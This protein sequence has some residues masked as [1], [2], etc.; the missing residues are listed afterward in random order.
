VIKRLYVL[1]KQKAEFSSIAARVQA[2]LFL[3][4][5]HRGADLS[6][7]LAKI[8]T[9]SPGA[10]PFI[11]DVHWN[12]LAIQAINDEFPQYCQ[13]LQLFSFYETEPTNLL[14]GKSFVLDK[15]L[16]TLGYVNERTA[17]LTANHRG[18]CKYADKK[19]PNYLTVRNALA[20]IIDSFQ[21]HTA[22]S[23]TNLNHEEQKLLDN[24]LGTSTAAE[25][26]FM[27]VDTLRMSGSCEWLMRKSSYQEWQES[28]N[29]QFYWISAKPATGK[30][31]LSGKVVRHLRDLNRDCQFY[32]FD[33]SD[34]AKSTITSFLLSMAG[35]MALL[36][37]EILRV[38]LRL[39]KEDQ[40]RKADYRTVW[41][42]LYADSILKAKLVRP[43]FWVIDALHECQAGS[44]LI[45]LLLKVLKDLPVRI[46][47]TSCD[48]IEA[49]RQHI[50][51]GTKILSEEI[52][53]FDTQYDIE[54]YLENQMDTLPLGDDENR[55]AM[56]AQ[57]LRKA[58]GCFLW[59]KLVLDELYRVHTSAEIRQV[60]DD[61]PSDM[62]AL[63]SRILDSMSQTLAPKGKNLARAIL[64]WTLC[65]ACALTKDELKSALQLY[66][67]D[68][69]YDIKSAII[70]E[71][72]QLVHI[73]SHD[74]VLVVHQ[75]VREFLFR[76]KSSEF[77][78]D[79]HLGHRQLAM[80]CLQYL[81]GWDMADSTRRK[82][83]VS[84]VPQQQSHFASYACNSFFEHL[85]HV[86]PTDD[87]Q[88]KPTYD[89][90]LY[91]LAEFLN[92]PNVLSWIE[93]I[94]QHSDLE[95]LIQTSQAIKNFLQKRLTHMSPYSNKLTLMDSC[96]NDV[97]Q[98]K[99]MLNFNNEVAIMHLWATDLIRLVT[100]FRRNLLVSPSSI[101]HLIPPFCPSKSALRK[102]FAGSGRGISL[103][104]LNDPT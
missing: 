102:L 73:D 99:S 97:I 103:V 30:T 19:D 67:G 47:L 101:Y 76:A 14:V 89:D 98:S 49:Y 42:I 94:A 66:I 1:A 5:P 12:S 70:S 4:T 58:D 69:V 65:A 7:L 20:S 22:S 11:A 74:R 37:S 53:R 40:V 85:N 86:S 61:V 72:G 87:K 38:V 23:L 3:A 17:Y 6:Q 92:S 27:N 32:F 59:V 78:I 35:Q 54:L 100:R 79:E 75:T 90:V 55:Q 10:R 24:F 2:I 26:D 8:V 51:L 104:G 71:C 9:I 36:H 29:T 16:A 18:V 77:A 15:D 28:A 68:T 41:R 56:K 60:L 46:F 83:S 31:V 48:P 93:Y 96:A 25:D 44:E 21:A 64:T 45:P 80:T 84:T 52:S 91:A 43:Q 62:D 88:E 63:Y 81:K 34:K 13:D 50:P 39:R 33:Y 82:L 57:I 95:R